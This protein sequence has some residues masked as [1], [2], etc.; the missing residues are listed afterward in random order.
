MRRP[1]EPRFLLISP[2]RIVAFIVSAFGL[3]VLATADPLLP[4]FG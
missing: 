3:L 2:K 4:V 1:G